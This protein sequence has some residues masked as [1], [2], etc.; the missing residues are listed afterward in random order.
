MTKIAIIVFIAAGLATF[1]A[2]P[3]LQTNTVKDTDPIVF[4]IGQRIEEINENN[5]VDYNILEYLLDYLFRIIEKNQLEI[6]S[7]VATDETEAALDNITSEILADIKNLGL[8]IRKKVQ[9]SFVAGGQ[10]DAELAIECKDYNLKLF[11]D[12]QKYGE[13][14]GDAKGASQL[15]EFMGIFNTVC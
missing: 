8:V 11:L 13:L 3:L 5:F 2:A 9:L 1:N 10:E 15:D 7:S 12:I 6:S 4:E 14:S